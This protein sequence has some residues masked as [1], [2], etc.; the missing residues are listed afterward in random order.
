MQQVKTNEDD[1]I[2][3]FVREKDNSK[4]FVVFNLSPESQKIE[5]NDSII[6]G[7][8]KDFFDNKK[9]VLA[10]KYNIELTAWGYKVYT[11]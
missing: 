8:Y 3:S 4:V 10:S 5:I 1:K 6:S 9:V 2:F 7:S 11:K